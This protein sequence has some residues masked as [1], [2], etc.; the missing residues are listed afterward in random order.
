[1]YILFL[2]LATRIGS[3]R[4]NPQRNQ[5][6]GQRRREGK[7]VFLFNIMKFIIYDYFI[8]L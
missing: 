8:Y 7:T 2:F 5:E 6:Q 3:G 1:M 4:F